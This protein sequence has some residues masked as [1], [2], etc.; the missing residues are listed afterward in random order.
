MYILTSEARYGG[1][2][3]KV[4][5]IEMFIDGIVMDIVESQGT[6]DITISSPAWSD[7]AYI[8]TGTDGDGRGNWW[9]W[10]SPRYFQGC[11]EHG[12]GG[13][14]SDDAVV[15]CQRIMAIEP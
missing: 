12:N 9:F 11:D 14:V 8:A 4:E 2:V 15:I 10:A 13:N 6:E 3:V 5:T 1:E 7:D